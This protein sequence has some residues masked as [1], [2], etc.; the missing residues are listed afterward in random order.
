V[1]APRFAVEVAGS[2]RVELPAYGIA[3]AE[4]RVEKELGALWPSAL[5]SVVEVAGA[6]TGRIVDEYAV[7]YRV[8]GRREVA[9][10]SEEEARRTALRELRASFEASRFRRVA[11]EV[12]HPGERRTG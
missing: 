9:A 11:W 12:I 6:G 5:V 4:H 7:R 2:G 10:G 3:D 1:T 8:R